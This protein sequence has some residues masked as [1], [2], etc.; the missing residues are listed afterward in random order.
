MFYEG[1]KVIHKTFCGTTKKR[2]IK[3]EVNFHF[4]TTFWNARDGKGY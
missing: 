3:I 4:N 1:F 2:E